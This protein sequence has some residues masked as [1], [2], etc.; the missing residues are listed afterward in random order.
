[1]LVPA[2]NAWPLKCH[3]VASRIQ[4]NRYRIRKT[5]GAKE[6]ARQ[7]QKEDVV[8]SLTC[9]ARRLFLWPCDRA[10]SSP[11][12]R[13]EPLH[14]PYGVCFEYRNAIFWP[15]D[16]ELGLDFMVLCGASAFFCLACSTICGNSTQHAGPLKRSK[17]NLHV[18]N[19]C[20][21]LY[22]LLANFLGWNVLCLTQATHCNNWKDLQ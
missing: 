3:I 20:T 8:T 14:R 7:T 9:C 4:A 1:M 17:V 16:T 11:L 12:H 10:L 18:R 2:L 19:V 22:F 6:E 13:E 21:G 5:Q 15:L